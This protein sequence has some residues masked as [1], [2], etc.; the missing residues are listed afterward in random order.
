MRNATPFDE[1]TA[2]ARLRE[3]LAG[4]PMYPPHQVYRVAD[5]DVADMFA[6]SVLPEATGMAGEV[7]YLVGPDEM[8]S[9]GRPT[10]TFDRLM[11]ILGVGAAPDV[12]DIETFVPLFLHL[13]ALRR[14]VLLREPDGHPLLRPGQLPA[15][16]FSPPS[17][18]Y[19]EGGARYQFWIFDIDRRRPAFFDVRVEP[20]GATTVESESA[21]RAQP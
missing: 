14:G 15:E 12:M 20:D 16:A 19:G 3:H 6:F 9:T 8:L 13:R 1:H 2:E 4:L 11:A 17:Y 18:E 21:S 7:I 5:L 10:Q